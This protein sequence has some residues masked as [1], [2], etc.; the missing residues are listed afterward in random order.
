M[1]ESATVSDES[2]RRAERYYQAAW[3]EYE[4]LPGEEHPYRFFQQPTAVRLEVT[5]L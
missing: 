4:D 2:A 1:D 3:D 5:T